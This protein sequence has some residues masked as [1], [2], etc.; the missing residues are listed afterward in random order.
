MPATEALPQAIASLARS[1][2]FELRDE[3]WETDLALLL[4]SMEE[5]GFHRTSAAAVRYPSPIVTPPKGH[6]S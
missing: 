6:R 3:R 1:Q 2:A 4:S 5:F